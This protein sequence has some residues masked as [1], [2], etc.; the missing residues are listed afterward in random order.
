MQ[1]SVYDCIDTPGTVIMQI[2][3][4]QQMKEPIGSTR[5]YRL[6]DTTDIEG[7]N[8]RFTGD[9]QLTRTD[10]GILVQGTLKTSIELTCSRCLTT[11]TYPVV[12]NIEEEFFPTAD[13]FSG[14]VLPLPEETGY[15]T[16][17]EKHILNLIEPLRQY[18]A[19]VTPMK[20]LCSDTCAGLCSVCGQNLNEG[21][22]RCNENKVNPVWEK[23]ARLNSPDT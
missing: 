20:P 12:M 11:F 3:V 4:S 21:Q 23:L 15:F 13:V 19:I 2:N 18:I 6:D 10:R 14:T 1:A 16:I 22:C 9:I 5:K 7:V 8:T 17:D